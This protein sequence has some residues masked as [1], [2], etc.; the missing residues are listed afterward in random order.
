MPEAGS[1]RWMIRRRKCPRCSA[2][3]AV[4]LCNGGGR[5]THADD[6]AFFPAGNCP[7]HGD[8]LSAKEV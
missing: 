8:K 3:P 1:R 7:S 5:V 4:R 6:S 2:G